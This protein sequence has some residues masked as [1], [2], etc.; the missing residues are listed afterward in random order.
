M[1]KEI[2]LSNSDK[3]VLV[4]DCLFEWLSKW[5]WYL[6][7]KGYAVRGFR[8]GEKTQHVRMHRAILQVPSSEIHIDH[9]DDNRL[10]NQMSNLRL[11]TR[12]QNI[13]NRYAPKGTSKYKGVHWRKSAKKWCAEITMNR[14]KIRLGCF[15]DEVEA[16]KAYDE[17]ARKYQGEFARPNFD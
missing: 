1:T 4:D 13:F 14:K 2:P 11:A 17:A 9:R 7:S 5:T 15:S 10:N 12:A 3:K 6:C 16:A 8:F